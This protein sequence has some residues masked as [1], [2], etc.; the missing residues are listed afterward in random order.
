MEPYREKRMVEALWRK[1]REVVL[2]LRTEKSNLALSR[3]RRK[4][5][6]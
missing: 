4:F 1:G 5:Q 6:P 3:L 2:E